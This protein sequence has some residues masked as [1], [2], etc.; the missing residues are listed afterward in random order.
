LVD[1]ALIKDPASELTVRAGSAFT[2]IVAGG[3]GDNI[4][5]NGNALQ[6]SALQNPRGAALSLLWSAT[7]AANQTLSLTNIKVQD[8]A[9][10]IIFADY[11]TFADPGVVA[12]GA[13][14]KSGVATFSAF[15]DGARDYVR[16]TFTPNL[17][18]G[19]T[20]TA[21]LLPVFVLT[22]FETLPAPL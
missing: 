5:V 2:S 7:L 14:T 17:S 22:G 16:V 18:A 8:S 9:D 13:G 11:L 20:D 3:A 1:M 21:I 6:R 12:Q 4:A 19:A 15:L 10:G